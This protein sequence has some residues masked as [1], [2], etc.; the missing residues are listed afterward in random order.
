MSASITLDASGIAET[1]AKLAEIA[2]TAS[3][4]AEVK[5]SLRRGGN[6]IVDLAQRGVRVRS[7][8][9]KYSIDVGDITVSS[10]KISVAVIARRPE[11]S[12]GAFIERGHIARG[13]KGRVRAYPYLAPALQEGKA[14]ALKEIAAGVERAI[15]RTIK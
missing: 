6:I 11:G 2:M 3:Q 8:A 14:D 7:G 9:L 5:E 13:R 15:R 12:H 10:Q 4:R 1:Y